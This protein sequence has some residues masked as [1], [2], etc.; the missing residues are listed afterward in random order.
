MAGRSGDGSPPLRVVFVGNADWSVPSLESLA[1]SGHEVAR[2]LT[3]A[4]RPAGRGREPAATPVAAAARALGLPL[5][6]TD[7]RPRRARASTPSPTRGRTSSSSWRTARSLPETRAVGPA[8]DA[9]ER[10]LLAAAGAPRRG[11]GA[12]RDP[13]TGFATPASPRCGWTPEW[14]RARSCCS[15]RLPS[16]TK[17]TRE[18]SGAAW[19]R[20][21]ATLLVETLDALA[22][23]D[24]RGASQDDAAATV[25]PKLTP[26][27]E[28]LDWSRPATEIARRVRALAPTPGAATT[29][30]WRPAQGLPGLDTGGRRVAG[31][32]ARPP[33]PD[34]RRSD[35]GDRD[36]ARSGWMRSRPRAGGAWPGGDWAR[37]ART[38]EGAILGD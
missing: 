11:A 16:A 17:R 20:S 30:R 2:V 38:P 24:A 4:P 18:P 8:A 7:D 34:R 35:R 6:E 1:A 32:R 37:G 26:E 21:A 3:R 12:A 29:M 15:G 9:G 33:S 31:C 10:P 28:R 19:R 25:A 23:G 22:G 27:D 5:L 36:G 13:R 14:T